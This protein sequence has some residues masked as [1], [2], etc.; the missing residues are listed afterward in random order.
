M[1]IFEDAFKGGSIVTG[2]AIGVGIAVLAPILR[3][4][5]RPITKSVLKAGLAAYEQGRVALAELNEQTGDILAEARA[6]LDEEAATEHGAGGPESARA[7]ASGS[8]SKHA[9]A[10]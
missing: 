2:L 3:P 4:V 7:R 1:A 5:V 9:S 6:E 8:R 10:A